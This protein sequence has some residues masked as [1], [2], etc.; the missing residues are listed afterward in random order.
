LLGFPLARL[1]GPV[2]TW[3]WPVTAAL[4]LASLALGVRFWQSRRA[5][6]ARAFSRAELAGLAA[7]L[8]L[9]G[10]LLVAPMAR[11]GIQYAVYRSN[12]SDALLYMS[13]AESLRVVEWPTLM[14]GAALT[15]ANSDGLT[16]LAELSP[17]AL[18]TARHLL[19][20]L[21]LNKMAVLAW[22]VE[23]TGRPVERLYFAHHLLAFRLALPV[24]LVIGEKLRLPRWLNAL[25]GLVVV[26]GFWPRFVLET[27]AGYEISAAPLLLLAALAWMLL[28][29]KA[30]TGRV[31]AR[32]LLA[33]ALAG[34]AAVYAPLL[35]VVAI[36][37]ALYYGWGLL[38]GRPALR[39]ALGHLIT[40]GLALGALA[41]TLQVDFVARVG[42]SLLER[43]ENEAQFRPI[44]LEQISRDGPAAAWGLPLSLLVESPAGEAPTWLR[45]GG[46][47]VAATLTAML[48][49]AARDALSRQ[50]QPAETVVFAWLG[51]GLLL[52]LLMLALGNGRSAGK[53]LTYVAPFLPQAVMTIANHLPARRAVG[54]L[55]L[56]A[57]AGWLGLQ[58]GIGLLLPLGDNADFLADRPKRDQY[59]LSPITDYLE[60]NPPRLLLVNVPREQGWPFAV[61][62]MFVFG[63][64]P[65]H[66]Q[67]GLVIDNNPTYQN[68]WLWPLP[69]APDYAVVRKSDD[70]IGVAGLGSVVA[71]SRDL[72]LYRITGGDLAAFNDIEAKT[73]A[74]G[75]SL[76][77]FPTLAP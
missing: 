20:P 64:Y 9:G 38:T 42:A 52:A 60:R 71:E 44:V 14:A 39:P 53:S 35:V 11:R 68:L 70:P 24:A 73:R 29:E 50:A 49:W 36:A 31:A 48:A 13:L 57:L 63:R 46:L 7:L 61:Y 62:T 27:D 30:T 25:G 5:T 55:A 67:S 1:V 74:A 37:L 18:F 56:A 41:L 75:S 17:T 22:L 12:P 4:L 69:A 32:L 10:G 43:A 26:A 23:W 77:V 2:A 66:F 16:R 33:L 54:R 72:L 51:A 58:I 47:A 6:F 65:A 3:V 19:L 15:P 40:A 28:E 34:V 8:A 21:S 45:L 59:N 76:A